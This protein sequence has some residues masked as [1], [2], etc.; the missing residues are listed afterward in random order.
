MPRPGCTACGTPCRADLAHLHQQVAG[1]PH[2]P[3]VRNVNA[4]KTAG[5]PQSP[6]RHIRPPRTPAADFVE[7]LLWSKGRTGRLWPP[8]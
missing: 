7:R 3:T 6:L 2:L 8:V 4:I 5:I 1:R